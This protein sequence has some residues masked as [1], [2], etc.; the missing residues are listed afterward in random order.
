MNK[1]Y[2]DVTAGFTLYFVFNTALHFLFYS[3]NLC[4]SRGTRDGDQPPPLNPIHCM[5]EQD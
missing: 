4:F 3:S 1:N 5:A 2:P